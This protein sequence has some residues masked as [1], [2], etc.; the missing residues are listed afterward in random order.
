MQPIEPAHISTLNNDNLE[1]KEN[2]FVHSMEEWHPISW[3]SELLLAHLL[4]L[5][6]PAEPALN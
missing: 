1:K 3:C 4:Q 5:F 6:C 2:A